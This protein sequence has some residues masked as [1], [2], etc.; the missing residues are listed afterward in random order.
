M[1]IQITENY[2]AVPYLKALEGIPVSHWFGYLLEPV[3]V[4]LQLALGLGGDLK[5][6]RV[7]CMHN[8]EHWGMY[9][10]HLKDFSDLHILVLQ[11][12][13]IE[14]TRRCK[15]SL[16]AGDIMHVPAQTAQRETLYVQGEVLVL[17]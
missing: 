13:V 14:I 15:R 10:R 12:S 11:N 9:A 17:G 5:C 6:R 1:D 7:R 16:H 3:P 2:V 4:G 8:T